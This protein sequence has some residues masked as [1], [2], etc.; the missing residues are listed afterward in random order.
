MWEKGTD[1]VCK[2]VKHGG[3]GVVMRC[4]CFACD[5]SGEYFKIKGKLK[6]NIFHIIQQ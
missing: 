4:V 6:Q 5:T 2:C 3:G 1:G